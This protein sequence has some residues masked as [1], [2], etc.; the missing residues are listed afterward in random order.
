[1][2]QIVLDTETTGLFY[3]EGHRIVEVGCVE[4]IDRQITGNYFH[5]YVNPGRLLDETVKEI[6][7]I[8]DLFLLN[9]PFFS[10]VVEDFFNFIKNS[11]EIIIHNANFDIN[12]INNELRLCNFRIQDI[13]KCFNIFDTL[14]FAR[15][16]HPGK[17]N[18]LSA[19]CERYNIDY[20]SR[21]KHG[22]LI[23]SNLLAKVY[24]SMTGA[25]LK[26][27]YNFHYD[28]NVTKIIKNLNVDIVKA[29]VQEISDHVSYLRY[30]KKDLK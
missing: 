5:S 26:L 14:S 12:F 27:S 25:Q 8:N 6:I 9:K 17:K 30:I 29:N 16:K 11:D 28:I 21:E 15:K 20:S 24:L 4:I 18:S 2:R 7:G 22:A 13:R 19:L 3:Y 23:D 1:M 10:N